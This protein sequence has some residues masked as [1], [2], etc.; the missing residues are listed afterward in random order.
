MAQSR[1]E[2]APSL[3]DRVYEALCENI[4]TGKLRP[5]DRLVFEQLAQEFGVSLTPVRD[6]SIR[7][8]RDGLATLTSSGR[9]QVALLTPKYVNDVYDVRIALEGVAASLAATLLTTEDLAE[10]AAM[11]DRLPKAPPAKAREKLREATRILHRRIHD[12]STNPILS[13]EL[14]ALRIHADY[15]LGY[16]F[17]EFGTRYDVSLDEHLAL[18]DALAARN[19]DEARTTMEVHM[20]LVRDRIVALIE[21]QGDAAWEEPA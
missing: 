9:L 13:G 10:L 17:R 7:L 11:F 1:I 20:C 3:A 4:V 5:A 16:V 15:I 6:A 2:R 14:Q 21:E 12:V 18:L 8:A 19:P